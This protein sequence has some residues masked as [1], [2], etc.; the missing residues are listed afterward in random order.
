VA[1]SPSVTHR[2][3]PARIPFRMRS[4]RSQGRPV[5]RSTQGLRHRDQQRAGHLQRD[6]DDSLRLLPSFQGRVRTAYAT[7]PGWASFRSSR[8]GSAGC[9]PDHTVALWTVPSGTPRI[10][11]NRRARCRRYGWPRA[12]NQGRAVCVGPEQ[13]ERRTG[14]RCAGF[15][16]S[17]AIRGERGRAVTEIVNDFKNRDTAAKLPYIPRPRH[18]RSLER[19]TTRRYATRCTREPT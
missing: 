8:Q 17:Q 3:S 16:P 4:L 19:S 2:R 12:G 1:S 10:G 18:R 9:A 14:S 13:R 7:T 6:T 5:T 11:A 15:E